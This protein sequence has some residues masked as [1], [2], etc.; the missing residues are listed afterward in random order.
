[1]APPSPAYRLCLLYR[2]LLGRASLD[3]F[4]QAAEA[5]KRI[6]LV[7]SENFLKCEWARYDYKT[8]FHEALRAHSPK[9]PI[10]VVL[11]DVPVADIDPD[12]M[13]IL[14]SSQVLHWS[15]KNFWG[16]F[17]YA[18]PDI[19]SQAEDTCSFRYETEPRRDFSEQDSTRT[20]TIH[21]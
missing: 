5:S 18:M 16:K 13:L 20:M 8:G 2:D 21:I 14:R 15:D 3:S 6:V 12:L 17:R 9:K 10:V 11:G 1:M 7:L 19:R 4:V